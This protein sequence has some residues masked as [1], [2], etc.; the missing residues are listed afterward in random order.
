MFE[1]IRRDRMV[2]KFTGNQFNIG[3]KG[4]DL[5]STHCSTRS[6]RGRPADCLDSLGR[7][8]GKDS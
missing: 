8:P 2:V 5:L 7:N 3:R 4:P 1:Q 6:R